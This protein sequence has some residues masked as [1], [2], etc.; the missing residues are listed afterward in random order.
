MKNAKIILALFIL[1]MTALP[2][3]SK[4]L[5]GTLK[6][7]SIVQDTDTFINNTWVGKNS[8]VLNDMPAGI[9][10]SKIKSGDTVIWNGTVRIVGGGSTTLSISDK[11]RIKVAYPFSFDDNSIKNK[12]S[13]SVG[14][15]YSL[16]S[17]GDPSLTYKINS[18]PMVTADLRYGVAKDVALSGG[19]EYLMTSDSTDKYIKAGVVSF[20][21]S[22]Y[23]FASS[24]L[25]PYIGA[26]LNFT[27]ASISGGTTG[28]S[29]GGQL[30]TGIEYVVTERLNALAEARYRVARIADI[31]LDLSG[32]NINLGMRYYFP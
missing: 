24:R 23:Y 27:Y 12:L 2:S 13:G 7:D 10:S 16:Y 18:G 6:V 3:L 21:A 9:Y 5:I 28:N 1:V 15:G 11:V 29:F 19:I 4:T 32:F 30:F 25:M 31:K 22:K 26:G 20:N 17:T 14:F 8:F